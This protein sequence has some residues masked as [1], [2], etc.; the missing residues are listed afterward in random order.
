MTILAVPPTGRVI[1][2]T[3]TGGPALPL[4]RVR[5]RIS[6]TGSVPAVVL[7]AVPRPEPALP[8]VALPVVSLSVTTIRQGARVA[9]DRTRRFTLLGEVPILGPLVVPWLWPLHMAIVGLTAGH[10]R[11]TPDASLSYWDGTTPRRH[12]Q[13]SAIAVGA[14]LGW[15]AVLSAVVVTLLSYELQSVAIAV[16]VVVVAPA[17][18]ELIGLIEFAVLNPEWVTLKR[19]L[20]LRSDGRTTYVL[21]SLV[22]RADGHDFAGRLM[23]L[24]YPQWQQADAVVIGYPASKHLISYYVRMGARRERPSRAGER[25]ARRRITFDCRRPLRGR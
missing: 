17:V 6:G 24:T 18:V 15:M 4:A 1:E 23:D 11:H 12:H 7:P 19:E 5:P 14:F 13:S 3:V 21:T 16:C 2:R 8:V 25:T 9:T 22:S 20:R 10:I